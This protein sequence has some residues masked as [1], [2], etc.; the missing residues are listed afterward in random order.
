MDNWF[1]ALENI[2]QQ[3]RKRFW[4]RAEVVSLLQGLVA[5]PTSPVVG[6]EFEFKREPPFH[7]V[8]FST[9]ELGSATVD[10]ITTD[11]LDGFETRC[12]IKIGRKAAV[13]PWPTRLN[14]DAI[15][16]ATAIWQGDCRDAKARIVSLLTPLGAALAR[17]TFDALSK[18]SGLVAVHFGDIDHF[19][20]VNNALGQIEGDRVIL[21]LSSIFEN[22]L[23]DRCIALHRS[24]DEF[25]IIQQCRTPEDPLSLV[26]DLMDAFRGHNFHVGDRSID[27]S[28]GIALS[29]EPGTQTLQSMEKVAESA[30]KP[31]GKKQR[32]CAR[33]ALAPATQLGPGEEFHV[34]NMIPVV[35]KSCAFAE[36]PFANVW[37]NAISQRIA[38]AAPQLFDN[39]SLVE[40]EF[41]NVLSWIR[42]KWSARKAHCVHTRDAGIDPSPEFSRLDALVAL[43]HSL[44][45]RHIEHSIGWLGALVVRRSESPEE[46]QLT[47][48]GEAVVRLPD[49]DGEHDQTQYDLGSPAEVQGQGI[50]LAEVGRQALLVKIGHEPACLP[51]S[52]F[53]SVVVVDDRPTRGGGLPDFWEAAVGQVIDRLKNNPNIRA[54]FVVGDASNGAATIQQLRNLAAGTVDLEYFAYKTGVSVSLLG[55]IARRLSDSVHIVS[56]DAVLIDQLA[57]IV[58]QPLKIV[59]PTV[60]ASGRDRRRLIRRL[61][62]SGIALGVQD[63]CRVA[64][65]SDAYPAVLEIVRRSSTASSLYD[66]AGRALREVIDFRVQ[67]TNPATDLVPVFYRREAK[68][69]EAYFNKQFIAPGGLFAAKLDSQLTAVRRHVVKAITNPEHPIATRRGILVVPHEISDPE[70]IAPLGLVSVRIIPRFSPG[71]AHLGFSFT[72]RT[73]EAIVGFPYSM[74]GSIRYAQWITEGIGSDVGAMI[75]GFEVHLG[76]VSYIAHSLHMFVDE[77]AERIV[78]SIVDDASE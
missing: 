56:D 54:V 68:S 20:D 32:G 63:G 64:T 40:A 70:D 48:N 78:R 74:F 72:W 2:L 39:P 12:S 62:T 31:G 66:Q 17:T 16:I 28:V 11:P 26:R 71:A 51:E 73:V 27:L 38:A 1:Q 36:S 14:Q 8:L 52:V 49:P 53:D 58:R 25:F 24:G 5:L 7:S 21:E 42:P 9:A 67:L 45:R 69:L 65:P 47:V 44:L 59:G 76:E 55:A 30:L 15:A 6:L 41:A 33:I 50:P 60:E 13:V 43:A 77:N 23:T 61:E 37:L 4:T 22:V 57:G 18:D 35:V 3:L 75:P 19:G 10:L 29:T 46:W 34:A